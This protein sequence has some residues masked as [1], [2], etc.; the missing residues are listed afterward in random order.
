M[1]KLIAGLALSLLAFFAHAGG[2]VTSAGTPIVTDFGGQNI[3]NVGTVDGRDVS[4]DGAKLDGLPAS[5]Y[6]TVGDDGTSQT[7]R[8]RINLISGN[9]VTVSCA[10][11]SG[12]NS[13][14]CTV[15]SA[16]T[17]QFA[18]LSGS[19]ADGATYFIGMVATITGATSSGPLRVVIPRAGTI[20]KI[21]LHVGV[22]ST[23]GTTEAITFNF[24]LNN[25]TD[26]LITS[27]AQADT[28]AQDYTATVSIAVVEGDYFEIK[29]TAPTW[30]TNPTG[31]SVNGSIYI[32]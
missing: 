10:D 2:T 19:P 16:Y 29:M 32:Q 30:V 18:A 15:S 31:F 20:T 28:A 5:A 4:A 11:N 1:K 13:T 3:T 24:R 22:G 7:Q 27:A 9:G 12:T 6:A 23:L 25:T 17:M 14:D 26:T 8:G 21:K